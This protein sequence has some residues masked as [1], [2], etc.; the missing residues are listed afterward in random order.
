MDL[1]YICRSGDNEELRYS[2]RSMVKNY[3]HDNIWVVG[4][5]PSWYTGNH[6]PVKQSKT[7]YENAQNNLKA[8]VQSDEIS[9][10]FVIVNDDFYVIRPVNRVYSFVS[11][12][13]ENKLTHF[14]N[15]H[16][17][18]R[19]TR[20]IMITD[21]RI[22]QI[23]GKDF[24]AMDYDIH[25]PMV[26]EKKKLEPLLCHRLLWRSLYGNLYSVP[27]KIMSDVKVYS[28]NLENGLRSVLEREVPFLSSEDDSFEFLKT[29]LLE[30]MFPTPSPYEKDL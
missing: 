4:D 28:H 17:S 3:P 23:L 30:E 11:G 8:I 2:I 19:Y 7:K 9:K 15:V 5:K 22:K 29:N 27:F 6:I 10:R 26:Y 12:P 1:V 24:R 13:L 18:S 20:L 25:V 21:K 14:R 16:P